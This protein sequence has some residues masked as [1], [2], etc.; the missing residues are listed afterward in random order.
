MCFEGPATRACMLTIY[1][2]NSFGN[3]KNI[4]NPADGQHRDGDGGG[5][6]GGGGDKTRFS[7]QKRIM[8]VT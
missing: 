3:H 4:T 7:V 8:P 5:G 1:F 6:G 2:G